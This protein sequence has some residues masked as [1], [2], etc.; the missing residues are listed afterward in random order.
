MREMKGKGNINCK[1]GWGREKEVS[2][3]KRRSMLGGWGKK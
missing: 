1:E 3:E 2:E